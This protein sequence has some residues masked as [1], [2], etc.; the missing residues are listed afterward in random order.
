[1]NRKELRNF[2]M[3][4]LFPILLMLVLVLGL[5]PAQEAKADLK[6]GSTCPTCGAGTLYLFSTT[7]SFHYLVCSNRG[8]TNYGA[9]SMIVVIDDK[10][11]GGNATCKNKAVCEGCG[12][13]YG[14]FGQHSGGVATC[15]K[16]AKCETCGQEYGDF[17]QHSGGVDTCTKKAKC[18]TCGQEYGS[19]LGHNWDTEWSYDANGHYHKCLNDGCTAKVSEATHSGGKATCTGKAV[20]ETCGQEYGSALGHNWD[21]EWSYD[22]NSHYYKCL[23]DG[24]TA[25]ND[26]AAHSGGNATCTDKA[27][28]ETC[29]QEYDNTLGHTEVTDPAVAA[30][31]TESG[32]TEGKH[33]SVC[34]AILAAQEMIPAAGHHYAVTGT[35]ITRVYYRCGGCGDSYWTDNRYSRSIIPDLVR[36]EHGENVDYFASVFRQNGKR[37]LTV[38]PDLPEG[39][40]RVTSLWL[41]PEYVE[42]WI[43]QAVSM[44]RIQQNGAVLEIELTAV[45]ADWFP[46]EPATRAISF[47]VFTL[48]PGSDGILVEVNAVFDDQKVPAITLSGITLKLEEAEI[49]VT[50]NGMRNFE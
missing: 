22:E 28:C 4:K 21:T 1:M 37:I 19:A 26:E 2:M 31:C 14:D 45:T 12:K 20:C 36:D 7:Q 30:T 3:K 13:E 40:V 9:G 49:S 34:G 27:K 24:C 50:E 48:D 47:Y 44:V 43:G 18:E 46:P 23:N 42:Q 8:C 39:G 32:K 15:T 41:N 17:G 6:V 11:W 10:H 29:G 33:C 35:S 25:K 38:T 5:M 16:K